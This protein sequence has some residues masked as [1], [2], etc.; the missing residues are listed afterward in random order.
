MSVEDFNTFL[1]QVEACL[2]S[3]PLTAMSD[4]PSDLEPLT[5]GHFL[6]GTA[7]HQLPYPDIL[8]IPTNRLN[9]FQMIQ[10]RLQGFWK[11]WR[12]EYLSQLQGRTKR[13]KPAIEITV[14]KLVVLK[15]EKSPPIHW[16]MGRISDV[17]PG[18]DGVVRVV[19]VKTA[20]GY[21]KRAVE[22]ICLLPPSTQPEE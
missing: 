21:L 1:V 17:H 13:W 20:T 10:Q 6:I 22:K 3:R 8:H 19:T 2:N 16:K 18:T 7:L 14:G 15:D 11:R 9:N 5:P 4:D 12:T